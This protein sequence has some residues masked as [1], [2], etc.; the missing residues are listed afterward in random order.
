[1]LSVEQLR[2]EQAVMTCSW[3]IMKRYG[4]INPDDGPAWEACLQEAEQLFHLGDGE[5]PGSPAAG[6]ARDM[7]GVVVNWIERRAY[8]RPAGP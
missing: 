6:L 4:D 2:T 3:N 1:M 8:R 7:A 5:G